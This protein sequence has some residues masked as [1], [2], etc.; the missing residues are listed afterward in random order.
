[1]YFPSFSQR[2]I[3]PSF[4]LAVAYICTLRREDFLL[5][6]TDGFRHDALHLVEKFPHLDAHTCE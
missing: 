1:M 5:D 6:F 4:V 3:T 2:G